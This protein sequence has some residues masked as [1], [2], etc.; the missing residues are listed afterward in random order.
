MPVY[1]SLNPIDSALDEVLVKA[2][3]HATG[4]VS[5]LDQVTEIRGGSISRAFRLVAAGRRW[6]LKLNLASCHEMFAAEADGL[7]AL[8]DCSAI[9]VPRVIAHGTAG[10]NAYLLLEYLELFPLRAGDSSREAGHALAEVHRIEGRRFGWHRDNFIGSSPQCNEED[11]DWS[12]FFAGRRLAPQI[13]EARKRGFKGRF[14]ADGERLV[15]KLL[16]LFVGYTPKPS[17]LHGDLWSGNAALDASGKLA[18]FDPAVCYGDRESDLAMMA[19]FGGFPAHMLVAYKEAW[20]LESG[21]EER[22][23]L[24]QLYHILNHMNLFGS[25]YQPQAERMIGALLAEI[26]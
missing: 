25:G 10:S 9:R 3:Q 17:L 24:Y 5:S 16:A 11:S 2:I 19:L 4:S 6:F 20:P 22:E 13:Q 14:I 23:T 1:S 7:D 8:G 26:G 18:L 15:E 21:F 12:R